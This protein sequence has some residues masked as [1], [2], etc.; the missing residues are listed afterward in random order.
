M[1]TAELLAFK[2]GRWNWQANN[3]VRQFRIATWVHAMNEHGL[4]DAETAKSRHVPLTPPEALNTRKSY[5]QWTWQIP[6][7]WLACE[8][9][10]VAHQG[11]KWILKRINIDAGL[12]SDYPM[13]H[14]NAQNARKTRTITKR[15][16]GSVRICRVQEPLFRPRNTLYKSKSFTAERN[17]SAE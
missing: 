10:A 5:R 13:G 6:W 11:Y 3:R 8:N 2:V 17:T 14:K 4:H 9:H 15:T 1:S 16:R 12:C 7:T